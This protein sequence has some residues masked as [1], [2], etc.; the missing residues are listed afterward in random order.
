MSGGVVDGV[1]DDPGIGDDVVL[2]CGHGR[3]LGWVGRTTASPEAR[4]VRPYGSM[5]AS[6]RGAGFIVP[7][8]ARG[9]PAGS[10]GRRTCRGRTTAHSF[11]ALRIGQAR[12]LPP[13]RMGAGGRDASSVRA[14]LNRPPT[15]PGQ[16]RILVDSVVRPLPRQTL[17]TPGTDDPPLR[18][19][20]RPYG[21]EPPSTRLSVRYNRAGSRVW[22]RK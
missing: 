3:P 6:W 2:V 18:S 22:N 7:V 5:P 16:T 17:L 15:T 14:D 10:V 8:W 21:R 19:G 13:V 1:D 20:V 9:R 4:Q 11:A 12:S